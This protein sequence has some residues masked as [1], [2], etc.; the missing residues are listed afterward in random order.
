MEDSLTSEEK[1]TLLRI[2]RQSIESAVKGERGPKTDPALLTPRLKEQGAS[3]VT[4]TV[5]GELRG[6]IGTLEPY[7]PLADDVHEHA[8][9]A[10]LQ[11]PRFPPIGPNEL[12]EINIEVSRLSV[13]Y[14][15]EYW[16]ASSCAMGC[17]APRSCRKYGRRSRTRRSSWI[18]C[19]TKW[20]PPLIHGNANIW[21]C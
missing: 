5:H 4:L 6:C 7:Q 18:T 20:V 14:P 12:N 16:M 21:K 11:D 19:A 8:I 13:P 1:Q 10:A 3:F 9:A 15:L 2:A 17:T